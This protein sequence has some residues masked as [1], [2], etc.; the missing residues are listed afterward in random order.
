MKLPG[1]CSSFPR[2]PVS[3]NM[4]VPTSLLVLK[5]SVF[6]CYTAMYLL[7]LNIPSLVMVK[8]CYSVCILTAFSV[9]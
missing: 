4:E 3:E 2:I 5:L 1:S 9:K 7:P 8:I 6:Y